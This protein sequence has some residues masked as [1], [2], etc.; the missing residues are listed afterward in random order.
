[1]PFMGEEEMTRRDWVKVIVLL[2]LPFNAW[3]A[4]FFYLHYQRLSAISGTKQHK[5]IEK[6]QTIV[7][8][9]LREKFGIRVGQKI[10]LPF[11]ASQL[12][13]SPPPQGYPVCYLHIY[14]LALPE[15]W[16]DA[17]KEVLASP[18]LHVVLVR[19]SEG[20]VESVR[21]IVA[22]FNNPRLSELV[23]RWV[24]GIF[25]TN[26][27]GIL[28]VLCDGNGV[29]RVVEPYP[30]LLISPSL[31]KELAYWRPKLHQAVKR[32]LEKFFGKP[33]GKQDG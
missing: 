9:H 6:E 20:D 11:C 10:N 31:E 28:V 19:D 3:L 27:D 14:G 29:I 32:A 33:L 2:L 18:F 15:V 13:G 21:E 17:I 1:M 16:E 25:G 4:V 7:H 5:L 22:R 23:G 8:K 26:E 30:K 24:Y 12:I